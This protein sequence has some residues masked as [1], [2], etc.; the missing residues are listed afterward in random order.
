MVR[1]EN[2]ENQRDH[3]VRAEVSK[4]DCGHG[5]I[6]VRLLTLKEELIINHIKF[7]L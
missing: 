4:F 5:L 7:G 2:E 1:R 3:K 6:A